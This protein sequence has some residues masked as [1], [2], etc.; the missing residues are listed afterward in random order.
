[1]T[2]GLLGQIIHLLGLGSIMLV[3]GAQSILIKQSNPFN[4]LWCFA[5]IL[6]IYCTTLLEQI[7]H[8][9]DVGSIM[10]VHGGNQN[11]SIYGVLLIYCK[12]LFMSTIFSRPRNDLGSPVGW[13][14]P[15]W[16]I[17]INSDYNLWVYG[18]YMLDVEPAQL[19]SGPVMCCL[20]QCEV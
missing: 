9:L 12:T 14:F 16:A 13:I 19:Y 5:H 20:P 6:F 3:R 1:M 10:L 17:H 7:I 2:W 18:P 8:L 4:Y 15:P 11:H